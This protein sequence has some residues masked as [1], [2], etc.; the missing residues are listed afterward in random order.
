MQQV[1][2]Q[3]E[4]EGGSGA[5]DGSGALTAASD[6]SDFAGLTHRV[7]RGYL[8]C[9]RITAEAPPEVFK[10]V[11]Y[12]HFQ[13]DGHADRILDSVP[14]LWTLWHREGYAVSTLR[15]RFSRLRKWWKYNWDG[16]NLS[17]LCEGT[18]DL[19]AMGAQLEVPKRAASFTPED[20]ATLFEHK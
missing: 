8:E 17:I 3:L 15:A 18:L 4:Q 16:Q 11:D 20:L 6:D 7:G 14:T 2:D 10:L 9:L 13:P 19:L 12:H 5:E 1:D